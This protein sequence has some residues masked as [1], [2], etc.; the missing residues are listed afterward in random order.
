MPAKITLTRRQVERLAVFLSLQKNVECVTI[1]EANTSGIGP[2]H[3]ATYHFQD[4]TWDFKE[5]IS[6]VSNW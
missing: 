5:D 3:D 6:D 4:D 2:C 1:D